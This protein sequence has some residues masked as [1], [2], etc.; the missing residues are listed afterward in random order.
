MVGSGETMEITKKGNQVIIKKI[1]KK[2]DGY[3]INKYKKSESIHFFKKPQ[4]VKGYSNSCEDGKGILLIDYDNVEERIVLEDYSLIQKEFKLLQAYLFK[5][6]EKNWHVVCLQKFFHP[7]I[8]NILS[9]TRCDVNYLSMPLRNVYRNYVLRLG[10]KKG[11]KKPSFVKIIG[12]EQ[13]LGNEISSAHLEL[14]NKVFPEIKHPKY[15]NKDNLKQVFL[16][17]YETS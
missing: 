10:D 17:E 2:G 14:L 4:I 12:E 1:L 5:T 15:Y 13:Y 7:E 11:S 8:Y 3:K 9:H 16:Q 6:K